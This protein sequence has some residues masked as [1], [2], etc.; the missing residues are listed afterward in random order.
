MVK[1]EGG[2]HLGGVTMRDKK[3]IVVVLEEIEGILGCRVGRG[4]GGRMVT[5]EREVGC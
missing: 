3:Q 4:E 2:G 5:M 1:E